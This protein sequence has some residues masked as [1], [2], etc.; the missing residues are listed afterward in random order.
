MENTL[1]PIIIDIEASGFSKGS[2]PI[3]IGLVLPNGSSYCYL[4]QPYDD[5]TH[6]EVEAENLHRLSRETVERFGMDGAYVAKQL[7]KHLAN[8][9]VYTDAWNYDSSWLGLLFDR[10]AVRQKFKLEPLLAITTE[11]QKRIWAKARDEVINESGLK[12]HRAS[13]DARIIQSTWLRTYSGNRAS[14]M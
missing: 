4:I 8:E 12:R 3:E 14:S 10:A 11:E 9:T 13:A 1:I 7:N 2:Y 6:W 5:W